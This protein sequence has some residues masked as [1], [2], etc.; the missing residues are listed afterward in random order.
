MRAL[1]WKE[2]R[3]FTGSLAGL[4]TIMAFLLLTGLVVWVFPNNVL[5]LGYADL[6][7]LFVTAPFVFLFLVPAVTMRTFSEEQR[8]GTIELLLTKPLTE[9]QLVLAK[10]ISAVFMILLA[11]LP[12]LL[13]V[14]TIH[15]LAQPKG[16]IDTGALIGSYI[17]VFLL[18]S[19]F[20]AIGLLASA[21]TPNQIVAFLVAVLLC[22]LLF[23]GFDLMADFAA[24][25]GLE[26]PLK[27]L[28]I[29][30]HYRSMSRGVLDLKDLAYFVGLITLFL[31]ATRTAIQSRRWA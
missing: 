6:E 3:L 5:D 13:Y 10:Y 21:L 2:V 28:G 20:A 16:N 22:F 23:Q 30:A 27:D 14:F 1:V 25:G 31:A 4:V 7:P 11:L 15:D 9:W 12:T 24:V 18:G 19:A 8:T 29:L 17:G 26:G